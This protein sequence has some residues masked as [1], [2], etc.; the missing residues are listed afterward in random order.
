LR[1]FEVFIGSDGD[2]LLRPRASIPARELWIYQ[3]TKIAKSIH[4]G[5]KDT[6]E[7]RV[8]KVKK[9]DKFIEGL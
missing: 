1:P 3:D 9:L 5:I 6:E 8:T 2:I 7:G 4:K